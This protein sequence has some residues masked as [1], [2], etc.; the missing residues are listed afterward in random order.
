MEKTNYQNFKEY[1]S[2]EDEI[3]DK[4]IFRNFRERFKKWEEIRAERYLC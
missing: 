1:D 3:S 4:E 2:S